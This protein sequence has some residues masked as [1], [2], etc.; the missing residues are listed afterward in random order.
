MNSANSAVTAAGI[1]NAEPPLNMVAGSANLLGAFGKTDDSADKVGAAGEVI[2]FSHSDGSG[3]QIITLVHTGK[4]WVA[5][6][7]IS[8]VGEIRLMSSRPIDA[9]FSLLLNPTSPTPSEIEAIRGTG[10]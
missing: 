6:Y 5:V 7:H 8:R 1:Q 10:K 3:S 9:D 2:G 4:S